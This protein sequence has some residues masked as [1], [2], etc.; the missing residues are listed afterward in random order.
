[1][2]ISS[3]PL[4][5]RPYAAPAWLRGAHAQTIYPY[6]LARPAIVYRRERWE[7]DDGDFIDI[8]WLDKSPMH[9]WLCCFM[10]LRGAHAVIMY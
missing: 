10:G 4:C 9:R 6:F 3:F 7:L 2:K 1:M 8:D 5:A